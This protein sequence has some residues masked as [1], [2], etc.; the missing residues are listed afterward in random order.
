MKPFF[1]H[2]FS[3]ILQAIT[4]FK[5]AVILYSTYQFITA[6]NVHEYQM[7]NVYLV[8][9]FFENYYVEVFMFLIR[10]FF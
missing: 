6:P 5:T 3:I 10:K 4:N 9:L 8:E 1:I 7:Q 2:H